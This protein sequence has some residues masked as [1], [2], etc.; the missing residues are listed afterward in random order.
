[1]E[2]DKLRKILKRMKHLKVINILKEFVRATTIHQCILDP[3][4][5]LIFNKLLILLSAI[6]K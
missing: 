3:N 4:V 1:M 5:N 6:E 2:A